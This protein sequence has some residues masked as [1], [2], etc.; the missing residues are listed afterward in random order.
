M[1]LISRKTEVGSRKTEVGRQ[2]T[3]DR[4]R[5]SEDRS[6]K[7]EVRSQK[8][9]DACLMRLPLKS[10]LN[11]R[12]RIVGYLLRKGVYLIAS[13]TFEKL[14][15]NKNLASSTTTTLFLPTII[16]VYGL[17]PIF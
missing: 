3:E 9:E 10:I 11:I 12:C 7:S 2:K 4:S 13:F 6:R 8:S 17:R 16:V 14:N 15:G 1:C 5:K